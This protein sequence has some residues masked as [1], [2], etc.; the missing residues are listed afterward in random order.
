MEV[1]R[2]GT[3]KMRVGNVLIVASA[4]TSVKQ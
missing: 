4:G 2:I 3:E 1:A